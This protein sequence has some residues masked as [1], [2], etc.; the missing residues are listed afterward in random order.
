MRNKYNTV[1]HTMR[2]WWEGYR[3]GPW[4]CEAMIASVKRLTSGTLG[5]H[6]KLK[7]SE[8]AF[9]VRM[10]MVGVPLVETLGQACYTT[11]HRKSH[12]FSK[13]Y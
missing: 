5:D 12:Y 6:T 13:N 1:Q 11:F 4:P 7:V 3:I 9:K 10:Y 8:G 2:G